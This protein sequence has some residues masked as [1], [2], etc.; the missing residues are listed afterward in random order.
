MEQEVA[1]GRHLVDR[2]Q[3]QV[4]HDVEHQPTDIGGDVIAE[5]ILQ[6]SC[7]FA[8]HLRR[9]LNTPLLQIL[10]T[11]EGFAPGGS[12]RREVHT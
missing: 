6:S 1:H 4:A 11:V 3:R 2:W 7:A 10:I 12:S 8:L 5:D 9:I